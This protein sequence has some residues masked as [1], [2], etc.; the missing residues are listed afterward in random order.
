MRYSLKYLFRRSGLPDFKV[1][2]FLLLPEGRATNLIEI[3]KTIRGRSKYSDYNSVP[4]GKVIEL[5]SLPENWTL[6]EY[7]E[8]YRIIEE[9]PYKKILRKNISVI[10]RTC[11][12]VLKA[13]EYYAEKERA[14]NRKPDAKMVRAGIEELYKHGDLIMLHDIV[15]YGA[16]TTLAEAEKV[17]WG[18]AFAIMAT[19][20]K[21]G[22]IRERYM[23][24]VNEK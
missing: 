8:A 3:Y 4:I 19:I 17:E 20:A 7:I 1:R 18:I 24:L 11:N 9:V 12:F 23:K 10:F 2:K 13:L 16:A 6:L 14:I 22:E 5:R 21:Q 15:E